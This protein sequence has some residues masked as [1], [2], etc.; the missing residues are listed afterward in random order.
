MQACADTSAE[1]L[2]LTGFRTRYLHASAAGRPMN[3]LSRPARAAVRLTEVD[4]DG[5]TVEFDGIALQVASSDSFDENLGALKVLARAD[6]EN[7]PMARAG[8]LAIG[9]IT[10]RQVATAVRTRIRYGT[11]RVTYFDDEQG[12]TFDFALPCVAFGKVRQRSDQNSR[13]G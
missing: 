8:D 7:R 10:G 4:E 6:V 2:A 12:L 5:V 13:H 1:Q 11:H 3:L 9:E